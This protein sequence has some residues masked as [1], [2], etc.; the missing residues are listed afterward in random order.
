MY[1]KVE[2]MRRDE[3]LCAMVQPLVLMKSNTT[4]ATLHAVSRLDWGA[5]DFWIMTTVVPQRGH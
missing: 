1:F 4:G 3:G 2:A 5:A